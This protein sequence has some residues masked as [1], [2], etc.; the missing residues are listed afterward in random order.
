MVKYMFAKYL[1]FSLCNTHGDIFLLCRELL[2]SLP[3]VLLHLL[4][5]IPTLAL[6]TAYW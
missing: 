2:F 6:L 5:R 1:V 4:A 3:K